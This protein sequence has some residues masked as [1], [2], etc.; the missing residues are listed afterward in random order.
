MGKKIVTPT[1]EEIKSGGVPVK[2]PAGTPEG[3]TTFNP[4]ANAGYITVQM[5]VRIIDLAIVQKL[6]DAN[7]MKDYQELMITGF[8]KELNALHLKAFGEDAKISVA[9]IKTL[10]NKYLGVVQSEARKAAIMNTSNVKAPP[11]IMGGG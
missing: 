7:E 4:G 9:E 11:N 10:Y 6:I 5:G 1:E 3:M 8:M 2:E